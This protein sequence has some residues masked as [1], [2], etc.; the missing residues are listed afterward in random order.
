MK[1]FALALLVMCWT[2]CS[3]MAADPIVVNVWPGKTPG[4]VGIKGQEHTR[5]YQSAILG[6][7]T[8]PSSSA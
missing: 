1:R 5:I 8:K 2:A 3:V 7:P 4:D 6:E